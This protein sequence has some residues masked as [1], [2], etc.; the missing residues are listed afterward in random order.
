M[1][2][3]VSKVPAPERE[4]PRLQ[5]IPVVLDAVALK[6]P[7]RWYVGSP[8]RAGFGPLQPMSAAQ[9]LC[10]L[11]AELRWYRGKLFRP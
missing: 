7:G 11:L 2:G 8:V 9:K 6:L 4:Y 10:C 1:Q 5:G 3:S